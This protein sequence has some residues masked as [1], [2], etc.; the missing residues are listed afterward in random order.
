LVR[1]ADGEVISGELPHTAARMVRERAL[2]R[3]TELE[4]NWQR[5]IS[6]RSLY[7]IAGPD[8]L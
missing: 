6:L 2:L 8:D 3:R 4:E 1:I 7:K 5:A